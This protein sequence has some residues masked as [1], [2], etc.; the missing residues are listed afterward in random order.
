[1]TVLLLTGPTASGKSRIALWLAKRTQAEIISADARVVYRGLVIGTDRPAEDELAS[2]PH[3]LIGILDPYE[4]YDAARFR[5]D[6]ERLVEGIHHRGRRAIVAGGSTLYVR[7]L[8]RGLF[9]GPSADRALR[10]E[11]SA[12]PDDALHAQLQRVDPEASARI[13][14]TDRVRMIRALE[15]YRA[16]GVPQS[17]HFGKETPFPWPLLRVGVH[18]ERDELQQRIERRVEHM[19]SA[20]LVDEARALW[21][22]D[23]PPEAPA[24]RTIGYQ[25]LFSHFRGE[26]P[27]EEARKKIVARTKAYARRQM[28]WLRKEDLIWIDATGRE[29][30][31]VGREILA[32]W[33]ERA[34]GT[35]DRG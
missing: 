11:L 10:Q 32:M 29:M 6:C 23:L 1:M 3:H 33:E 25:E 17:V 31:E 7:A 13:G 34:S 35:P 2:V 8:T 27:L 20:G 26:M 19:F 30:A 5:A 21:A 15:I 12:L 14:P 22:R 18:V 9:P 24:R 28:A 4:I 16:T